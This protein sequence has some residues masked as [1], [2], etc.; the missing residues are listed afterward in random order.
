MRHHAPAVDRRSAGETRA[1]G[2]GRNLR[3]PA[4]VAGSD[5][6][7][8]RGYPQPLKTVA[9]RAVTACA[10][11]RS[12]SPVLA[13]T[14]QATTAFAKQRAR[15]LHRPPR[16]PSTRRGAGAK[17]NSAAPRRTGERPGSRSRTC[18]RLPFFESE[19]TRLEVRH[20]PLH[21]RGALSRVE[22]P[23][24]QCGWEPSREARKSQRVLQ[25]CA[26]CGLRLLGW[27][28]PSRQ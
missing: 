13:C 5:M 6:S 20:D 7:K 21:G 12:R 9:A 11:L 17:L 8:K 4:W 28:Q 26:L 2:P 15:T 19:H 18:G 16:S 25:P 10:P 14:T 3:P 23:V 27:L 1:V 24:S 22:V